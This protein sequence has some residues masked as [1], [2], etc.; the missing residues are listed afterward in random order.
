MPGEST[1]SEC[2]VRLLSGGA[3]RAKHVPASCLFAGA[4]KKVPSGKPGS[5][6]IM[7]GSRAIVVSARD[8]SARDGAASIRLRHSVMYSVR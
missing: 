4:G 5:P 3:R 6:G 8:A 1:F 2:V 7:N